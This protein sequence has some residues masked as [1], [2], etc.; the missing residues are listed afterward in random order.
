MTIL[1]R[2]S[3]YLHTLISK[4]LNDDDDDRAGAPEGDLTSFL[5]DSLDREL[6]G[7]SNVIQLARA[8][9]SS[10]AA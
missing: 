5:V 8:R 7:E 3:T 1:T 10:H 9:T 6:N 2:I 4:F